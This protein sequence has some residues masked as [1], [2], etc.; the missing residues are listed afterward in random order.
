M[1]VITKEVFYCDHCKKHGLSKHAMAWH[2]K[3]CLKNP[4][5]YPACFNC[6]NL[7]EAYIDNGSSFRGPKYFYCSVKNDQIMHNIS[8]VRKKLPEKHPD[9]F[10]DSIL[11]PVSCDLLN[12]SYLPEE[13]DTFL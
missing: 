6:N 4:K 5:N 12:I 1:K 13:A 10:K 2:E 11:M 9:S 3:H 8:A 7:K